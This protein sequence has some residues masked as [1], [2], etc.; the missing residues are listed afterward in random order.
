MEIRTERLTMRP[1]ELSDFD[2]G[3]RLWT[4]AEVVRQISGVPATREQSWTRLLRYMGHWYALGYGY[5][6]VR[7][8][9]TGAFVGEVGF[10]DYHRQIDPPLDGIPELGWALVGEARG[11]G[12]A[13][14]A[15]LAAIEWA[16]QHLPSVGKIACI[17]AP[18]NRESLRVAEKAGF[19]L[20]HETTYQRNPT[21][22]FERPL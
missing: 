18:E 20:A 7:E 9:A 22:V 12:Y 13:T 17:I 1:H 14:E 6:V 4:D 2:D 19:K 10:A 16:K 8:T 3:V 5:W 15:V 11:K 21:H